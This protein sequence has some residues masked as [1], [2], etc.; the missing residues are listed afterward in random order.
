MQRIVELEVEI[1]RLEETN[2]TLESD[3]QQ[4]ESAVYRLKTEN[5]V[6]RSV[7]S[8]SQQSSP[9]SVAGSTGRCD[10]EGRKA[11]LLKDCLTVYGGWYDD[12]ATQSTV[13]D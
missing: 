6:I 10:L 8:S 11:I 13:P 7:L 3:N 5:E 2:A 9:V 1:E 4:L 12:E